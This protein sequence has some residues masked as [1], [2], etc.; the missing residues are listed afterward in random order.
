VR[1]AALDHSG[2]Y[3]RFHEIE[4]LMVVQAPPLTGIDRW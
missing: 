3:R 2:R 1:G 4:R